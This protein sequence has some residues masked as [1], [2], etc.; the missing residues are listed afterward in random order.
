MTIAHWQQGWLTD[1]FHSVFRDIM[2]RLSGKYRVLIPVHC[3][4]PDHLHILVAGIAPDTDQLLWSRAAKRAL[5]LVLAP[6][7]LQKQAYDHVLRASESGRDA[8][9][10]LVHYILDNP[11]RAGLVE[12]SDKWTYCGSC[13]PQQS[14]YDAKSLDFRERWWAYWTSLN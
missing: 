12:K 10:A 4:M 2:Q 11:V 5:N 9:S 13:I 1:D 8:F 14:D 7:R 3:L 6:Y